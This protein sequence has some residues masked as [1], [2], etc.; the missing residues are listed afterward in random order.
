V[1][2]R[3][4][5]RADKLEDLSRTSLSLSLCHCVLKMKCISFLPKQVYLN[6]E[7][8][9]LMLIYIYKKV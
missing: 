5:P 1:G 3:W 6:F 9:G 7:M 8:K 4:L 2:N